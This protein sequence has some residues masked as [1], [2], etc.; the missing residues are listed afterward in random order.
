MPRLYREAPLYSIWEGSGNVI[1][2]DI[3]RALAKEPASIDAVVTE[4]RLASGADS[5]LSS[6]ISGV[7]TMLAKFGRRA[8]SE[9][10]V[11]AA[12]REARRLAEKLALAL[13]ASLVVRHSSPAVAE[14]FLASRISGDSGHTFGT[15]PG[16]VDLPGILETFS[17]TDAARI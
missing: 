6:F 12:E 8:G 15:L 13:Q 16:G 11:A 17:Q 9:I 4:M 14:A 10:D 7:E 2:L 1:C 5:R 3:L